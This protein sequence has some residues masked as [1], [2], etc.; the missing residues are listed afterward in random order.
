MTQQLTDDSF[1]AAIN[2][3]GIAVVDFSAT[4][5]GPCRALAPHFEALANDYDSQARF[6]RIDIDQAPSTAT[7]YA[8]MSVPTILFFKDGQPI[9]K[10]IGLK[11]KDALA[12]LL[13][14]LLP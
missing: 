4:W 13:L 12:Q 7:N 3:P 2:T 11:S 5:C 1:A 8:I 14:P 10:S 9:Q 6:Y